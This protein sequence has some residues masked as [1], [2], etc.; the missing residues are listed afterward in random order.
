MVNKMIR[1]L[2]IL[3]IVFTFFIISYNTINAS[4]HSPA[5]VT[6]VYDITNQKL[7]VSIVHSVADPNSHYIESVKITISRGGVTEYDETFSYTS[8]PITSSF[9]YTYN[10]TAIS[11]DIIT[12]LITCNQGGSGTDTLTAT[13][14]ID[15]STEDLSSNTNTEDSDTDKTEETPSFLIAEIIISS[16]TIILFRKWKK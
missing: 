5:S 4:A 15:T 11:G 16:L 7:N 1:K 2:S 14:N 12:V 3:I 6:A 13:D 10:V 8:Q 9:L